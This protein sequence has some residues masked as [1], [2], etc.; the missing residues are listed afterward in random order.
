MTKKDYEIIAGAIKKHFDLYL[1][2]YYFDSTE[3]YYLA[4]LVRTLADSLRKE[5]ERFY[6]AKFLSACGLE[7]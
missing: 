1:D 7:E 5:N 3:N 6:K 4:E 2:I